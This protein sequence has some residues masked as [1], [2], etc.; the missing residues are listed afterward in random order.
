ME[1]FQVGIL[2]VFSFKVLRELE[3]LLRGLFELR[4]VQ[5]EERGDLVHLGVRV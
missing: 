5:R 3:D 2:R 4:L 1:S